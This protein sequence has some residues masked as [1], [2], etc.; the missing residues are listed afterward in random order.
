[1]T[2]LQSPAWAALD[3]KSLEW[4]VPIGEMKVRTRYGEKMDL[5]NCRGYTK[6]H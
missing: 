4:H 2:G 6:Q 3:S 5:I 1:M